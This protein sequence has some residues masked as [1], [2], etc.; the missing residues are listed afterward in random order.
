MLAW[1]RLKLIGERNGGWEGF[2]RRGYGDNNHG[3]VVGGWRY[4]A[5]AITELEAIK[6]RNQRAKTYSTIHKTSDKEEGIKLERLVL[7]RNSATN[8]RRGG[9]RT[10]SMT[11]PHRL[12]EDTKDGSRGTLLGLRPALVQAHRLEAF[13]QSLDRCAGARRALERWGLAPGDE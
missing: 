5:D 2:P 8:V 9:D 10:G 13:L 4:H 7:S 11:S 1:S 3:W 6:K 12:A